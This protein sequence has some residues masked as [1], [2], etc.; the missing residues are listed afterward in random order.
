M[1]LYKLVTAK[2]EQGVG[3][4]DDEWIHTQFATFRSHLN[5]R[6]QI[7]PYAKQPFL[8]NNTQ[9]TFSWTRDSEPDTFTNWD[10]V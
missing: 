9:I 2:Y 1:S 8:K 3:K 10:H 6:W 4:L 5:K 7:P